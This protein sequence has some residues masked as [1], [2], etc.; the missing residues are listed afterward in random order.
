MFFY[1]VTQKLKHLW[2]VWFH[3]IITFMNFSFIHGSKGRRKSSLQLYSTVL[4]YVPVYWYGIVYSYVDGM[5]AYNAVWMPEKTVCL[6]YFILN[7]NL[8]KVIFR[9]LKSIHLWSFWHCSLDGRILSKWWM[10][11]VNYRQSHSFISVYIEWIFIVRIHHRWHSDSFVGFIKS[12][13]CPLLP[14]NC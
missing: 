2:T 3:A 7:G 14:A 8:L 4:K 13:W 1:S 11:P 5:Y 6:T 12:C 9:S 10:K